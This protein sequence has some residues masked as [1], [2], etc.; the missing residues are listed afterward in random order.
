MK[1]TR[2]NIIKRVAR[3]MQ[4]QNY[5]Q[6]SIASYTASLCKLELFTD[7]PLEEVSVNDFKG[8]LYHRLKAEE[9]S[10]S[11]LNQSISAYKILRQ[12]VLGIQ[13][14]PFRIKRPRREKKLP[15]VLSKKEVERIISNV[16]NIKHKALLSLAYSSG[17]RRGEIRNLMITEID[18]DQMRIKV[19]QGKGKK[20]RYT[21]LSQK[22][23]E[24]LRKYYKQYRPEQYLFEPDGIK[25][26]RYGEGTLNKIVKNAA[27]KAGIKKNISFHT[28]RHSFAT[29]LLENGINVMII[30]K[31]LG[32]SSIKT[33]GI[34]LH[35]ANI[36]QAKIVS[37]FDNMNIL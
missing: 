10:V 19:K 12:S 6:K 36:E 4:L 9:I 24:L 34:Y 16:K 25:G 32:H 35:V 17:M 5:S 18:S 15:E 23:L 22:T 30:K 27:E 11:T 8:F 1:K 26:R 33:T 37:P 7:K 14:E 20:D 3:E 13:W 21:I 31:L 29:H 28:L 2:S